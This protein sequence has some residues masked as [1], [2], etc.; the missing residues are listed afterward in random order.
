MY[1]RSGIPSFSLS[2]TAVR[3]YGYGFTLSE[4]RSAGENNSRLARLSW[5]KRRQHLSFRK[6]LVRYPTGHGS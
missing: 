4:L 3:R 6:Y 5:Q 2:L 1:R